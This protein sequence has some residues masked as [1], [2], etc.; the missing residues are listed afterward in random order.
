MKQHTLLSVVIVCILSGIVITNVPAQDKDEMDAM[1][2]KWME[3]ATPGKAHKMLNDMAGMWET[4]SMMWMD[5]PNKQPV[6]SKGTAEIEWIMGGRYLQQH[7][8]GEMMGK[9]F[10]GMSLSG[11][12][13]LSKQYTML[14]VDDMST[15]MS[16]AQGPMDA[17]G[18]MITYVGTMS[19]PMT[20]ESNKPVMYTV[21]MMGK[22]K[23]V[24][25]FHDFSWGEGKTKIGEIVYSRKK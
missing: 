20:G 4:S 17:S 14:W 15:A 13:N 19:E 25:E 3:A 24:F 1:M 11:Y 18:T 23:F 8:H 10:T 12:D 2:K 7:Y 9:P 16:T 5:G 6:Q 22:D 21:K